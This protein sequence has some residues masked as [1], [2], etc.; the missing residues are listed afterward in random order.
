MLISFSISCNSTKNEKV[1]VISKIITMDEEVSP[2]F[3]YCDIGSGILRNF[4]E[5]SEEDC[6]FKINKLEFD[7][8]QRFFI[9]SEGKLKEYWWYRAMGVMT[10]S[11]EELKNDPKF[12]KYIGGE[13]YKISLIENNTKLIENQD[14]LKI[15]K[16]FEK[17]KLIMIDKINCK[18]DQRIFYEYN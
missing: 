18:N 4:E 17:P 11:E 6:S 13:N 1:E 5:I 15:E 2:N 16:I 3:F 9:N 7:L 14:T 10:Y 8:R 12:L